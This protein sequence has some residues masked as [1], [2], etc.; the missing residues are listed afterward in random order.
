MLYVPR[1][2]NDLV[3]IE[4]F[5]PEQLHWVPIQEP[6]F[7]LIERLILQGLTSLGDLFMN[8]FGFLKPLLTIQ[9]REHGVSIRHDPFRRAISRVFLNDFLRLLFLIGMIFEHTGNFCLDSCVLIETCLVLT[10]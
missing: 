4:L 2:L 5:T 7:L 10:I 9:R 8:L 1:R 3:R 6:R